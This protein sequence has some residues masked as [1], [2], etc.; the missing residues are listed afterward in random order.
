MPKAYSQDVRHSIKDAIILR[1]G[2]I[3]P[4]GTI[5]YIHNDACRKAL[6]KRQ[7]QGRGLPRTSRDI[8]TQ[9]GLIKYSPELA[10][11]AKSPIGDSIRASISTDGKVDV[12]YTKTRQVISVISAKKLVEISRIW[13]AI[14]T[15]NGRLYINDTRNRESLGSLVNRPGTLIEAIYTDKSHFIKVNKKFLAF[16]LIVL[17]LLENETYLIFDKS[18]NKIVHRVHYPLNSTESIEEWP[19]QFCVEDPSFDGF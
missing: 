4:W 2:R 7:R 16:E 17:E 18:G 5:F 8:A 10:K 11:L 13:S 15:V 3:D 19:G 14:V 1:R 12:I 6:L 9:V